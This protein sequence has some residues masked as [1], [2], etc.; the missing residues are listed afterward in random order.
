MFGT[1]DRDNEPQAR[2][3]CVE[4]ESRPVGE[5]RMYAPFDDLAFG[6]AFAPSNPKTD[7][8]QFSLCQSDSAMFGTRDRD[9]EQ[10]F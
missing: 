2:V 6:D 5:D 10:R 8:T 3:T 4:R 1:R 9:N 7:L